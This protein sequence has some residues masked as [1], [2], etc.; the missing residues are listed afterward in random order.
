V[1]KPATS[2]YAEVQQGKINDTLDRHEE[3]LE[4]RNEQ[5]KEDIRLEHEPS[6]Q[7]GLQAAATAGLV[8]GTFCFAASAGKK[9]FDEGK[10][11]FRGDF[12]KDDWKEVGLDTG[13][14]AAAGFVTGGAVYYLTNYVGAPAP[15]A[16]AFVSTA[17]GMAVLVHKQQA[18]EL[19]DGEFA[20]QALLLCSDVALVS[21]ASAAGQALIPVPVLGA[22]VGSFAGKAACEL[23]KGMSAKGAEAVERRMK[24]AQARLER[25]YQV[26]LHELE[27]KFLPPL[28]FMEFAFDLEN[29]R[30]LLLSSLTL[31][32]MVGVPERKLLKSAAQ[33]LDFLKDTSASAPVPAR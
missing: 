3:E 16:S 32:R 5:L 7:E 1:V 28:A 22:L 20:D 13:K 10:N 8:A 17:K 4:S 24:E 30:A 21:L 23:L 14:A 33:T 19:A 26:K 29:N 11:I 12:D 18:G 31:G 6:L 27:A 25:E 2:T 9:Y 15:L